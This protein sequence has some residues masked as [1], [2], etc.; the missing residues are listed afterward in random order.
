M[1]SYLIY[2]QLVMSIFSDCFMGVILRVT[3]GNQAYCRLL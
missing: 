2:N 3:I 1:N